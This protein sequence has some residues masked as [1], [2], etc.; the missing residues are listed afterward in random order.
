[1]EGRRGEEEEEEEERVI[2][3]ERR[4]GD[5]GISATLQ[6]NQS[7]HYSIKYFTKMHEGGFLH[8]DTSQQCH[9]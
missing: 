1:M 7:S 6:Y 8:S 2:Q 3:K 9:F 5:T 4:A